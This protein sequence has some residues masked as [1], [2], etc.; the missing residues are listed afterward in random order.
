MISEL[1]RS[2]YRTLAVRISF[3]D[4]YQKKICLKFSCRHASLVPWPEACTGRQGLRELQLRNLERTI[5][6]YAPAKFRVA[7]APGLILNSRR[8]LPTMILLSPRVTRLSC[9]QFNRS[10][11]S[12]SQCFLVNRLRVTVNSLSALITR[13]ERF[14]DNM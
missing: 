12:P 13:H 1:F 11:Y 5:D 8:S 14:R 4:N 6:F 9:E 10:F 3:L 7:S 2:N